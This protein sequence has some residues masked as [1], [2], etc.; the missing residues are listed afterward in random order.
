M[1]KQAFVY[2]LANRKNGTLY[3][4]VTSD[5]IKRI[6]KHKNKVD[7]ESFTAKYEIDKLVWYITGDSIEGAIS[8]EKK[9]KNRHRSW[10]INLIEK[11]NPDWNDL[12]V[13]FMD[14]ATSPATSPATACRV[15]Q[16]DDLGEHR[17]PVPSLYRHPACS[18]R[19]YGSMDSAITLHSTQNDEITGTNK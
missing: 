19:V 12:S 16:N 10:K 6:Y 14:S 17:H 8:L 1:K 15:V 5:L 9:I 3:T 7:T 4:G 13:D 2:I 11:Q 18:R